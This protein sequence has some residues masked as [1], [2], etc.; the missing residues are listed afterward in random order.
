MNS[1]K[2]TAQEIL[3][4]LSKKHAGG[5]ILFATGLT[6]P[7]MHKIESGT[8]GLGS[9]SLIL[10][11]SYL[12]ENPGWVQERT[13][14]PAEIVDHLKLTLSYSPN[15]IE[16]FRKY[17]SQQEIIRDRLKLFLLCGE[18]TSVS[19]SLA[20]QWYYSDK[21]KTP[22]NI[23]PANQRILFYLNH[24]LVSGGEVAMNKWLEKSKRAKAIAQNEK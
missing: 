3:K 13:A 10:L 19:Q 6:N 16:I 20:L 22:L 1:Y 7:A 21:N 9:S 2:T 14:C 12:E 5:S 8:Q 18:L 24:D 17:Y 11:L 4:N 15:K 23:S